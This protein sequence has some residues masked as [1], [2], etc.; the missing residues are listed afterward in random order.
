M[1]S[2]VGPTLHSLFFVRDQQSGQKFLVDTGA[3]VSVMPAS[4]T[5]QKH[6]QTDTPLY[7]ANGTPIRTYG[8]RQIRLHLCNQ[9]YE[10]HF[11]IAAVERP[12]LGADFLRCH[13]L[14]VNVRDQ[15]LVNPATCATTL[16]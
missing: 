13:G 8:T 12:L 14:L 16:L 2:A 11:H 15:K 6:G 1:A 7:A 9:I 3:E 10:W 5:D 4:T